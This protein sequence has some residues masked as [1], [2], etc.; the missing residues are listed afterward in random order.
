MKT[1]ITS[2]GNAISAAF[3]LRFGRAAWFCLFDQESGRIEFLKNEQ[4]H[5]NSGAGTRTAEKMIELGVDR[6]ISGDFG[7]KVKEM[8]EKFEI[9]LVV[10]QDV[11]QSIKDIIEKIRG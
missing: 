1:V 8:M 4:G 11:N 5:L 2:T 3:D 7:P 9:Q 6:I 10:L